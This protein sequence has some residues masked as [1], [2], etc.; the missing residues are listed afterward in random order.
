MRWFLLPGLIACAVAQTVLL[1]PLSVGG[2]R[3][4]LFLILVC[5]FSL[6]VRPEA[7]TGMGFLIGVYQD[8]LSGAPLGLRA[9]TYSLIGF[10]VARVSRDVYTDKPLAQFWLLFAGSAGAGCI[11]FALLGFFLGPRSFLP[12]LVF[13]IVPEAVY[14]AAAGLLVLRLPIVRA[15]LPRQA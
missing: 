8:V 1:E 14:T 15:A 3:P 4:D 12:A 10:L 5:L 6:H 7:S 2:V 13:V 9:F 11:T